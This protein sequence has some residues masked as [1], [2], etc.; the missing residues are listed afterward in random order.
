VIEVDDVGKVVAPANQVVGC[1]T[2]FSF[3]GQVG[4][5]ASKVQLL[6]YDLDCRAGP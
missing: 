4:F 6:R 1:R 2:P 5:D 3:H